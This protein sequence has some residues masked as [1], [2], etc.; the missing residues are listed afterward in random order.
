M[1]TPPLYNPARENERPL[2]DILP[3]S[4][5]ISNESYERPIDD[6]EGQSE[7]SVL[8]EPLIEIEAE[9]QEL[10]D[11]IDPLALIKS[12]P[13]DPIHDE[14]IDEIAKDIICT[15]N[16][17]DNIVENSDDGVHDDQAEHACHVDV[18]KDV[19][20]DAESTSNGARDEV[21]FESLDEEVSVSVGEMPIP[22]FVGLQLKT[23]DEFSGKMNFVEMVRRFAY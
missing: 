18:E 16:N 15:E 1:R 20:N 4:E 11:A 23:N 2:P 21:V 12:E 9:N 14:D 6:D 3:P 19:E 8:F 13:L 17:V 10:D 7:H 5:K 22:I